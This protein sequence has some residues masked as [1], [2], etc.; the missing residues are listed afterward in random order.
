VAIAHIAVNDLADSPA[1]KALSFHATRVSPNWN[2]KR[3]AQVG[4]HV[5]Y[6]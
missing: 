3:V 2:M 6:R 5:F 1:V 4:N